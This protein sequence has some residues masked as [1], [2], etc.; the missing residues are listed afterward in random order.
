M[1]V[2]ILEMLRCPQCAGRL[3]LEDDCRVGERIESGSLI[4]VSRAHRYPIRNFIPRFVTGSNYADNFGVQWNRFR[5]TQLD[6]YSGYPISAE[7]FWKS[8]GWTPSQLAGQWVLDAGCGAGRFAEIVLQAGAKVLAVDYSTAIDACYAN[9][10]QYP[11]LHAVQGDIY[12]LP[13]MKGFF[14]YVYSLGVLQ[15]TPGVAAAFG[16]LPPMVAEG[17]RLSVDIYENSW[18][19]K[20]LPKQWL[21]PIT[22]RVPQQRLFATLQKWVPRLFSLSCAVGRVPVVGP[23]LRNLVPVANYTGKLPLTKQQQLEWSLLDTFDWYAAAYDSPQTARTL[24]RWCREAGMRQ[25]EVTK[26]VQLVAR[27]IVVH[28]SPRC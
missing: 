9:L 4:C 7:R 23:A 6:S 22:R 28:E 8:T 25:I 11:D 19:S 3:T 1:R 5:Q 18:R 24:A 12:A 10:N 20:L 2:Q 17:G 21:R 14:P 13:L 27:G 15:H 26:A 16:A